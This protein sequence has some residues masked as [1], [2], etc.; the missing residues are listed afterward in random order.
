MNDLLKLLKHASTYD[1]ALYVESLLLMIWISHD[2]IDI[3][4]LMRL[5]I[6]HARRGN[7][8]KAIDMTNKMISLDP[9]FVEA[10]NKRAT[11][12]QSN[13]QYNECTKS[14]KKV[15]DLFPEHFGARTGLCL[16]HE[17]KG[18]YILLYILDL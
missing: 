7:N 12:Q 18:M 1:Q 17:K 14:A 10:Y 11:F 2:S 15:L 8:S 9:T 4:R 3:N 13:L 5:S 6:L 16:L